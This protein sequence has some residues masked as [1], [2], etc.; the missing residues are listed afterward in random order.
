MPPKLP[1]QLAY[2]LI[3]LIPFWLLFFNSPFFHN[4]KMTL[5]GTATSSVAVVRWPLL[6]LEK[7][8]SYRKSW[9]ENRRLKSEMRDLKSRAIQLEELARQN[10]RYEKLVSF[11]DRRG[12][13]AV[14]ASVIARDPANWN[15]SLMINR[16]KSDG[17][18]PGMAVVNADGVVGKV[19][20]TAGHVSK[21]ILVNDTGFSVAAVD[22]RSRESGLV[23]GSLS[24]KCRMLYLP[25]NADLEQGD[26]VIT[27]ELSSDFPPGILVGS[28][29]RL[30]PAGD[31]GGYRAE[32]SPSVE[33][34]RIEEVLVIK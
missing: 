18:R 3:F 33:V 20:E 14:M 8:L 25:E 19:A 9:E 22:R 12:F 31:V 6:E 29:S 1:K 27:S 11:R 24:G 5:M 23:T 13:N 26:E 10:G 17:I 2:V 7:M 4:I 32:I 15:S 28:I 34:S 16:G 30:M 21:V